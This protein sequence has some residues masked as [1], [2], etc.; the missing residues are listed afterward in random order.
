M[1]VTKEMLKRIVK[2]ELQS[3]L[4]EDKQKQ[5]DIILIHN[6][7]RD[8]HH[9]G[10]RTIQDIKSAEE[11]WETNVDFGE[12]FAYPDFSQQDAKKAL[13]SG[14]IKI[15]SSYPIKQGTFVSPSKR[16]VLD[17]SGG[18]EPFSKIVDIDDVAWINSDEG[19][20]AKT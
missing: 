19:Q 4:N 12:D 11:A 18:K 3:V 9:V 16:M 6:P 5:L 13:E 20:Y 15:Y 10:I 17:Y 7:M 8:N 14:K 1:K 2:E